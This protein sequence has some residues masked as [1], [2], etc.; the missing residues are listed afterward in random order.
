[1]GMAQ[2]KQSALTLD[3]AKADFRTRWRDFKTANA[4]PEEPGQH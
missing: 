4:E 2:R 3:Q 1:M